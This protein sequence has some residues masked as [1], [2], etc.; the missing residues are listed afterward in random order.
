M[1]NRFLAHPQGKDSGKHGCRLLFFND[2]PH[3]TP[4]H[5]LAGAA[6]AQPADAPCP[7]TFWA[8]P[9]DRRVLQTSSAAFELTLWTTSISVVCIHWD[10]AA[11]GKQS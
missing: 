8:A 11:V 5:I 4:D 9:T 3:D 2:N 10:T 1:W 7:G 6:H